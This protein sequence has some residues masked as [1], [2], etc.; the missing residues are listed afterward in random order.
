MTL[1][2]DKQF[3]KNYLLSHCIQ[4]TMGNFDDN[5]INWGCQRKYLALIIENLESKTKK[6]VYCI[7]YGYFSLI[8][9]RETVETTY[10][11]YFSGILDTEL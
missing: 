2:G 11:L 1:T 10:K 7:I 4:C 3:G 6:N 5:T 8:Q 9:K